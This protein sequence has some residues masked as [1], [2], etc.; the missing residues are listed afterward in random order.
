M[1]DELL[2]M[3]GGAIWSAREAPEEPYEETYA[4]ALETPDVSLIVGCIDEVV[5]G[6]G[7]LRV[8][9]LRTGERLGVIRDLFVEPEARGVAVG[10]TIT[11]TL[12]EICRER[13]CV[14]VDAAALPGHRAAKN[15]FEEQGLT[16]RAIVMHQ[17]LAPAEE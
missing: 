4:R 12:I 7:Y 17:R 8:E 6:F 5:V 16:A 13:E 11:N 2:P 3:K 14:G 9:T 10:E 1:H 15:F